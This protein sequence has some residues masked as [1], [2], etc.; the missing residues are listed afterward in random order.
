MSIG[1][2]IFNNAWIFFIIAIV[3]DAFYLRARSKRF[4][5]KQPE[6]REG[7]DQLFKAYLLYLNIPW[8][9]MG[10]G[11]VFGRVPS[12]FSFFRPRDGNLFV[13]AFHATIIVLWILGIRWIYIKGG[14]E[15]LIKYPGVFN[16]E[17]QSSKFIKVYF[18]LAL[19]V[20]LMGMII[21]WAL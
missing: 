12:I 3:F 6:L 10:I 16:R 15:F 14:A 8:L 19:V 17:L 9:V 5:E 1:N 18:G 7:Y 13:L 11:T 21:M 2:L 20:G 4:I